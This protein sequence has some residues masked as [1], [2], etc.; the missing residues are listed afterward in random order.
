[1]VSHVLLLFVCYLDA[2]NL[3]TGVLWGGRRGIGIPAVHLETSS[4]VKRKPGS[5]YRFFIPTL[6]HMLFTQFWAACGGICAMAAKRP[7]QYG[8]RE[9]KYPFTA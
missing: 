3:E 4:P 2:I 6:V 9:S 1:V 5:T 8:E 7:K